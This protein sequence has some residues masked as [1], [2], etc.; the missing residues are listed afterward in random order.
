MWRN[1]KHILPLMMLVA[2]VLCA[3]RGQEETTS[4]PSSPVRLTIDLRQGPYVHFVKEAINTYIVVDSK[5]YHYNGQTYPLKAEDYYGFG[6]VI[7]YITTTKEYA[8]FDLGCPHCLN[9]ATPTQVNGIYTICPIC[10]EEYDLSS[11]IGN[12]TKGVTNEYLRHYT[13]SNDN[14]VL[15]ITN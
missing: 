15:R 5:G 2:L 6:G 11:G 9:K 8:A 12:P 4:V 14:N 1:T 7:I 3:C 13:V 10:G